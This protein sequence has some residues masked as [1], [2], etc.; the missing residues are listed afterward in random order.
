MEHHIARDLL[1]AYVDDDLEART[2]AELEQ[3]LESCDECRTLIDGSEVP[4]DLKPAG[5]E[6]EPVWDE[7]RMRKTV[8]RTLL[9]VVS[10]VVS[11][12]IIGF[13]VLAIVSALAVQPLVVARGDRARNA[14]IATW[15]LRCW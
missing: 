7:R 13:I 6:G 14:G 10:G 11:I 1:A 8:R 2:R 15:D 5:V 9:R 12:W 4:V 3:H